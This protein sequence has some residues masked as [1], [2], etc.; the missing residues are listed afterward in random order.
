MR[1][2]G[3][4]VTIFNTL[5]PLGKFDGKADEGFL[6]GYSVSSK[7]FRVFNS[8]ARIVQETLHINFLENKP[9]VAGSG[10]TWLFDIDTLT[11]S[12]NYQPVTAGNQPNPSAVKEHEFEVKM[13]ESEVHVS[14]SSSAKTKKHDDKTTREAKG[15][16]HEHEFEVKMPESEVHISL[17]SRFR[18]L[19]EEFKDFLDNSINEVNAASTPVHVVG[20]SSY[21]DT[22]QYPD[23]PNTPALE[24]ITYSDD[25]EDVG[26]EADFSNLEISITYSPIPTTKV[27]K[28]YPVTQII[29]NLSSAPQT[30]SMT[31][32][33]KE[34]GYTK[35]LKIPVRLK[36]CRRSFFNSRCKRNKTQLVAQR[37]TQDEGID[38][39]EVFT[40]FARIEAIRLFLAYASFMGFMVYQMDVKSALLYG[41]IEEEVYVCQ[42]SGFEDPD[43][44]DKVYKVVKSLYGLHQ[45]P[46][47]WCETLANYLLENGL[48]RRKI[49]QTL[50]IKKQKEVV[51]AAATT[52][53]VAPSAARRRK[54]DDVIEQVKRKEK[55]DNAV[56]RYQALK[57]KPHTEAHARKNMMI[58]LKNIA[59]F[60][61]DF[62]KGMSY[63]D[64]RPI[65]KKYFNSNVAFL[66]KSKEELEEEESR[67]LRRKTEKTKEKAAK[68]QKLDEEV[69]KLKKH[70]Q[71]IPNDEDDVY[72][73]AT[74][75]ALKVPVVDYKIH[76]K[77]NKP[78]Y[79]IISA[80]GT[81]QLFLSFLSLLR[82]FDRE[83]SEM[84]WQI[85]QDRFASS[86][87][88]NFSDDF[89]LITL[90]AMFEKP[91][92]ED[93]IWKNQRGVHG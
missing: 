4:L 9:N 73:E 51:T 55:E 54:E 78:Y 25:E 50:F 34:Q 13:P 36:L 29:G 82:N 35:L 68:K 2:F 3:C 43:Y 26:A 5:D 52:I 60:K 40:P 89:L 83:D 88:N 71:I 32:M 15:K 56:L 77:H 66:E 42:P 37:H 39:E 85:V 87:P 16:S 21:V 90:K 22:S 20:K 27:H 70:L 49:D 45:A 93:Q 57:R 8:R 79:K 30:R 11:K 61:M 17:S 12:M 7:A 1:P 46:R 64:I 81:H 63:D 59:G 41:T 86:K 67:A 62:F 28:D 80:D 47:A 84:L 23:D 74:P 19:S 75:L 92:V 69:E 48:Q 72:T 53:T 24:D 91:D 14:L 44:L 33:V 38:Y 18:N 31:R 65:F 76:T 6:I 58:Y 10:P